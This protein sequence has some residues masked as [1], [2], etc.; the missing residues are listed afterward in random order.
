LYLFPLFHGG[1]GTPHPLNAAQEHLSD[2]MVAYWS[3]FARTGNPNNPAAPHWQ[4]Y[5]AKA[6]DVNALIEPKPH[7]TFGYGAQTYH[8][9]MRNDCSFWDQIPLTGV[10]G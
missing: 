1:Q 6:D 10:R 9:N 2:Q 3:T 7:M 8:N 4:P 5:S